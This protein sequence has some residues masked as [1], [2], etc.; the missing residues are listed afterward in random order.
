MFPFAVFASICVSGVFGVFPPTGHLSAFC[1]SCRHSDR[2]KDDASYSLSSGDRL[3]ALLGSV[4]YESHP[5]RTTSS[6]RGAERLPSGRG[7]VNGRF[8]RHLEV[9]WPGRHTKSLCYSPY[10]HGSGAFCCLLLDLPFASLSR[11]PAPDAQG[12][13]AGVFRW[14][15]AHAFR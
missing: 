1:K 6:S 2:V 3:L 12:G 15:S 13:S 11:V 8:E 9:T 10:A 7:K 5:H 4:L 14:F